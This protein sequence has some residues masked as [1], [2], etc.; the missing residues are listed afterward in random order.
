MGS[1]HSQ[2]TDP[3]ALHRC[4]RCLSVSYC[5][6][7]CQK[8]DWAAHKAFCRML[9]PAAEGLSR[10]VFAATAAHERGGAGEAQVDRVVQWLRKWLREKGNPAESQICALAARDGLLPALQWARKRG[11]P[12]GDTCVEAASCGHR[13]IL[14]WAR[15]E[16]CPWDTDTCAW[17]AHG[18]HLELLRWLRDQGCPWGRQT[19]AWAAGCG[20]LAV[21]QWLRSE[22]CPW[23]AEKVGYNA[24]WSG[25]LEVLQWARSQGCLWNEVTCNNAA[26]GGH[27]DVLQWARSQGC[28]NPHGH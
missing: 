13:H 11:L 18:E 25:H 2:G 7:A 12:W 16:G 19:C 4:S 3:V 14:E 9:C 23:E 20:H 22:G 8:A 1:H 17:A 10:S 26:R 21:L 6:R 28:P 15:R 24:A 27:L 5:S